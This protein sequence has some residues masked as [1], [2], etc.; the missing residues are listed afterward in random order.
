MTE[1]D[2]IIASAPI[3]DIVA[4]YRPLVKS[5]KN[6]KALCPF[7]DDH[8]P[9]LIVNPDQNFAWCFACQSGGDPVAFLQKIEGI[10]FL[11][12][13]KMAGEIA[14]MDTSFL[15][16]ESTQKHQEKKE[17][18]ERIREVLEESLRFFQAQFLHNQEAKKYM[19]QH[20][21]YTNDTIKNFAVGYAP[22]D[23]H[24]LEKYLVGKGFSRKEILDSGMGKQGKNETEIFD[25]FR[26]R[27]VFP[28]YDSLGKVVG[29]GGRTL[30]VSTPFESAQGAPNSD[31]NI[32]KYLNSPDTI[33]YDKSK[34]LFGFHLAKNA[35]RKEDRVIMVEGNLDVMACSQFGIENTVAI[36]G[37]AFSADQAKLIKRFTK[38]VVLALDNDNAGQNA[39]ERLIPL[40]LKENLS[41]SIAEIPGGK[42]PDEALHENPDQVKESFRNAL[43]AFQ[44]LL[45]RWG[46]KFDI[47]TSE[48]KRSLIDHAFQILQHFPAQL[49]Q[50]ESIALLAGFLHVDK[51]VVT[52]EWTQFSRKLLRTQKKQSGKEMPK[53]TE[54]EP[55]FYL[56]GILI[57][58]FD[59]SSLLLKNITP[60]FFREKEE[61]ELYSQLFHAYNDRRTLHFREIMKTFSPEFQEQIHKSITFA[62]HH[63]SH[64]PIPQRESEIRNVGFTV[65]KTLLSQALSSLQKE[66]IDTPSPEVQLEF[67]TVVKLLQKFHL[68][69]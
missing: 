60:D 67:Q 61:K 21:K 57:R 23:F 2:H 38:N 31:Q 20:R 69:F 16:K 59:E 44:V 10:S 42:D 46:E 4:R 36:S 40:M 22:D 1:V 26:N 32:P 18:S 41:V 50:S 48:G 54:I 37:V 13:V 27:V 65:G 8:T 53:N 45:H 25:R 43:P 30:G 3:A 68:S 56:L 9:S 17:Y 6:F 11:E 63:L 47:K 14:G 29:F 62:D 7:H 55:K 52:D 66:M 15:S 34:Q 58:Y 64:L 33:L 24:S 19:I 49:E 12:A 28:F 5:G 35:I 39:T 51:T